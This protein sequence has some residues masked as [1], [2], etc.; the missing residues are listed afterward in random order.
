MATQQYQELATQFVA[1]MSA[2]QESIQTLLEN[3][4]EIDSR[5]NKL[6]EIDNKLKE[7]EVRIK[8]RQSKPASEAPSE[9]DP[10]AEPEPEGPSEMD[11]EDRCLFKPFRCVRCG[12]NYVSPYTLKIHQAVSCRG[13]VK[14]TGLVSVGSILPSGLYRPKMLGKGLM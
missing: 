6:P 8:E 1:G 3:T 10:V 11:I 13:T 9:P 7:M 2:I 4:L 5:L 14:G 12:R